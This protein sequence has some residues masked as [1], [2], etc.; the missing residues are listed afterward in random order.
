MWTHSLGLAL[1]SSQILFND[2][3]LDLKLHLDLKV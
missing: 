3:Q 2:L 1:E